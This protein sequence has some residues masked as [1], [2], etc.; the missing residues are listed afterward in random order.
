LQLERQWTLPENDG[1]DLSPVSRDRLLVTASDGVYRF[2]IGQG[3]FTPFELLQNVPRVKSVNYNEST[4]Q[5]VYTKAEESWWTYHIY[6]KH[7][8]KV[9]TVPDVRLYKA[10]VM[11]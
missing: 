7:P 4:G 3:R 5:L 1:H 11:K 6:L 2:D 8:D 9:L 10:R